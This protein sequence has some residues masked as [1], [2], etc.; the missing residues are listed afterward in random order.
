[1]KENLAALYT[2]QQLDTA[3]DTIKRQMAA[4]DPGR[5]ERAIYDGAKQEHTTAETH[6]HQLQATIRDTEL[7]QKSV[8]AKRIHEEKRLYGGTVRNPKELQ[9]LQE[10][11]EML[12]RQRGRL[13][14][15]LLELMEALEAAKTEEANKKRTLKSAAIALKARQEEYKQQA[16][17]LTEQGKEVFL[18]RKQAVP[19][20]PPNLLKQYETLRA[21]KGGLAIAGIIEG[22]ACE[23]CRMKISGSQLAQVH[24]AAQITFCDNCN[25]ILVVG[26]R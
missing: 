13:D 17:V 15:K 6:L 18:Q 12:G 1:L 3:L 22:D 9:A 8:E 16:E 5:A 4:L 14:E 21:S 19:P 20:V 11:V 24:E 23:G 2:L 7:E 26:A 25:R 10:E